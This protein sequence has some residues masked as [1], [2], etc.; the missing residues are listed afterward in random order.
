MKKALIVDPFRPP[1]F[2]NWE[3]IKLFGFKAWGP[4][5]GLLTVAS[6][7][8][9]DYE[10]SYV[11]ENI[12]SLTNEDFDNADVVFTGGMLPQQLSIIDIIERAKLF[13]K[14]IVV[15]GADPSSQPELYLKHGADQVVCGDVEVFDVCDD[16][17]IVLAS[18]CDLTKSPPPRYD[19]I[20][21][22]NYLSIPVQ[23]GR[24]CP[25]QCEFC[26]CWV[27]DG[28]KPRTKTP[29]Q[30]VDELEAIYQ[31][32]HNGWVDIVDDCI[33]AKPRWLKSV[34]LQVY[35]WAKKRKFP[36]R[37][38]AQASV[39]LGDNPE[40][41]ELMRKCGMHAVFVGIETTDKKALSQAHKKVNTKGDLTTRMRAIQN[42]GISVSSGFILGFDEESDDAGDLIYDAATQLGIPVAMVGLLSALPGTVLANRL[43]Q[44]GRLYNS[45]LESVLPSQEYV[46]EVIRVMGNIP[47]QTTGGGLLFDTKR[48]RSLILRQHV[49][50]W[51][52]LYD[53]E[54][55]CERAWTSLKHLDVKPV[56][57]YKFN[58]KKDWGV[59]KA[60]LLL[61]KI[62]GMKP[63][64]RKL[65]WKAW[66]YKG[67]YGL[68]YAITQLVA[69]LQF[70]E[71][72]AKLMKL[73]P[74]R[75][76]REKE[77]G[78]S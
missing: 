70:N 39:N 28:A 23:W 38:S 9:E 8:S 10:V 43:K 68:E 3:A 5:L 73:L 4:G 60:I 19:L 54:N 35:E 42:A 69:Y 44:E 26:Y 40:L 7:L 36:F 33:N 63:H 12:R 46:L 31:L 1:A 21:T 53:P 62:P 48:D 30:I 34:L 65:L 29:E 50:C 27:R 51:D 59:V 15:G 14:R 72:K 22:H 76:E 11:D 61:R 41:P 24:G 20:N 66:R 52:K 75:L 67:R 56:H 17:Q 47:D 25:Q 49:E 2:W 58:P 32:G 71:T 45:S 37:F 74:R 18:R 13:N 6:H 78:I 77:C 64:M 57:K 55:F 16:R